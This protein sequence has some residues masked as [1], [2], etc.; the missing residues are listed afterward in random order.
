[1]RVGST[2]MSRVPWSRSG[3]PLFGRVWS[4][5]GPSSATPSECLMEH[6]RGNGPKGSLGAAA[7]WQNPVEGS[8]H[9]GM[10]ETGDTGRSGDDGVGGTRRRAGDPQNHGGDAQA[11][12]GPEG[13][14]R[15][16]GGSG[17]RRLPEAARSHDG[18][19]AARGGAPRGH[20]VRLRI[21]LAA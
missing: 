8:G 21:L 11:A 15:D 17:A 10:D 20:R 7:I 16:A 6:R 18:A 19:G 3:G 1:M 13:V 14:H 5:I 12:S 9:G 4:V 2:S